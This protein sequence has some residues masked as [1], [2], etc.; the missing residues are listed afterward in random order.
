MQV[1]QIMQRA[2]IFL[3]HAA[4]KIRIAQPLIPRGFRHIL[5]HAKPLLDRLLAVRRHLLP[6]GQHI[7][8]DMIALL[9][10]HFLPNLR[11]FAKL[12]LLRRWQV[13]EP[14]LILE[15]SLFFLRRHIPPAILPVR[16]RRPG[17]S[18]VLIEALRIARASATG[19][20]R[21]VGPAVLCLGSGRRVRRPVFARVLRRGTR[22]SQRGAE[23]QPAQPSTE[24]APKFHRSLHLLIRVRLLRVVGLHRLRQIVQRLKV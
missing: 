13:P 15:D 21:P 19:I 8:A 10:R 12:L 20:R 6:L 2:L 24:L 5:Q 11:A 1:A 18:P 16:Q 3:T 9:R 7:V 22:Q 4:R 17:L 23:S 14:L